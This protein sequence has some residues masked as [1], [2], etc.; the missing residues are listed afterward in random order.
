MKLLTEVLES[1]I[2]AIAS[3][4]VDCLVIGS[5]TAGVTTAVELAERGLKVAIVEAGPFL[6]TQHVG[7][8]PFATREDLVPKIH[9][10]VRYETVWTSS[11][12]E[13]AVRAGAVPGNNSAWSAVGGRTLFWGGCTPRFLDGD[14]HDWPYD[15]DEMRSWYDR[16]EHPIRSSER[17]NLRTKTR[18]L[19][20]T[21]RRIASLRG[22]AKLASRLRMHPSAS[23][24]ALFE[25]AACPGDSTPRSPD[26]CAILCSGG[27]RTGQ[28]YRW[29][30]K[31]SQSS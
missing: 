9:D 27:L 2:E 30:P 13:E 6:L 19:W 29:L 5:G 21:A 1:P 18:H 31:P 7:S 3:G 15:A 16:A 22:F 28:D 24:Q 23:T 8:G 10:L 20:P 14:F 12:K 17:M 26:C 25:T 11:D 4:S